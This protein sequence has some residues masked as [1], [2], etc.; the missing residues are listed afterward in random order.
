MRVPGTGVARAA[1]RA[2]SDGDVILSDWVEEERELVLAMLPLPLQAWMSDG[3]AGA[4]VAMR[5]GRTGGA[6][7]APGCTPAPPRCCP[8]RLPHVLGSPATTGVAAVVGVVAV[9][10]AEIAGLETAIEATRGGR[11]DGE[12]GIA[13]AGA[14][15]EEGAE[16]GGSGSGSGDA[17][18]SA[19]CLGAGAEMASGSGS[20]DSAR[21][22]EDAAPER[23]AEDGDAASGGVGGGVGGG[24]G[25]GDAVAAPLN[26]V[27]SSHAS[28]GVSGAA[29]RPAQ[30]RHAR[31][32]CRALLSRVLSQ[33]VGCAAATGG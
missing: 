24:G 8:P 4:E 31:R 7:H 3:K 18:A 26:V 16:R 11:S 32:W 28:D 25:N 2:S 10:V 9:G 20:G 1:R 21:T 13:A 27:G 17:A 19:G 22:V 12:D 23:R 14:G 33:P 15:R 30:P 6:P 29:G 5:R